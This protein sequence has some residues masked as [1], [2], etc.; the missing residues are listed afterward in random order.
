MLTTKDVN[1]VVFEKAMRGYRPES[2]DNFLDKVVSQFD[3]D[4]KTIASLKNEV[5][6]LEEKMCLL[7]QKIEEYE[8]DED[9]LKSALLNAQRMGE[10]VISEA[11]Q[12]AESMLHDASVRAENLTRLAIEENRDQ[13]VE[14][15]RIK[16]DVSDFK[17]NV[18]NLYRQHIQSLSTLPE[19]DG[20]DGDIENTLDSITEA[21]E[22]SITFEE[23]ETIAP[24]APIEKEEPAPVAQETETNTWSSYSYTQPAQEE[25]AEEKEVEKEEVKEIRFNLGADE[26]E[27]KPVEEINLFSEPAAETFQMD[28]LFENVENDFN[29]TVEKPNDAPSV[30][31]AFKGIHFSD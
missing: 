9:N 25:Q 28:K 23:I 21:E 17:A 19:Y 5:E 4:A 7:A 26:T 20:E 27:A 10:S 16:K 31:D 13:E 12:K 1:A 22:Q 2:V 15:E 14:L 3:E 8:A 18:L 24:V 6:S 11:K 29:T 30:E